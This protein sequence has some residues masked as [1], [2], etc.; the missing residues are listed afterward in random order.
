MLDGHSYVILGRGRWARRI[1][2]ILQSEGRRVA[3]NPE[4]R[5]ASGERDADYRS[6]LAEAMRARHRSRGSRCY[7]VL[8]FPS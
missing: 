7:L 5:R 1:E 6:R 8:I 4:A 3:T 2:H